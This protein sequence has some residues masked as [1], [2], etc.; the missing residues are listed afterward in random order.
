MAYDAVA[1]TYGR[2][3]RADPRIVAAIG[4][5]IGDGRSVLNVGAGSGSY[6]PA[7]R[8]L[9]AVEPSAAMIARRPS[10]AAPV[11]R[12][13][14]EDLP[15]RSGVVDAALAVLTV[16]HWQD[17]SRGLAELRRVARDRVVLVTW[18]PAAAPFWLV[19]DYFPDLVAEDRRIFPSIDELAR[20][21]GRV[22]VRPL[23]V[24]SDCADGFLGAYWQRPH[25]YLDAAVRACISTFAR[26]RDVA[27]GLARLRRDLDSGEW[28]TRNADLAG[29]Q[30]LDVGYRIVIGQG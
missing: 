9:A 17:R 23:P 22:D 1:S 11:V 15:F 26:L 29:R 27:P 16:H 2:H 18:D 7:G 25:A 21:L 13:R 24:P 8:T 28:A 20:A 4:E 19:R 14:A 6:E 3:R 5:A 12:A 10:A 30:E